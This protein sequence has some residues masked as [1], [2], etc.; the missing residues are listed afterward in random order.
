LAA[1][2]ALLAL[3]STAGAEDAAQML[4]HAD[5]LC[6]KVAAANVA[7]VVANAEADR[8]LQRARAELLRI[9]RGG[10]GTAEPGGTPGDSAPAARPRAPPLAARRGAV[11]AAAAFARRV[12]QAG[13][14]AA[15]RGVCC[16]CEASLPLAVGFSKKQRP[17][18]ARVMGKCKR[19]VAATCGWH[20]PA[21]SIVGEAGRRV[22]AAHC[23]CCRG[24]LSS[25]EFSN[26]QRGR[27]K[28]GAPARCKACVHVVSPQ[29]QAEAQHAAAAAARAAA[30]ASEAEVTSDA[31]EAA[32]AR[33]H[34]RRA[35]RDAGR[36]AAAAVAVA[37]ATNEGEGPVF[38]GGDGGLGGLANSWPSEFQDDLGRSF[39]SAEHFLMHRKAATVGDE[40]RC[41]LILA[42]PARAV[43]LGRLVE[44]LEEARWTEHREGW[45][46]DALWRKFNA[47]PEIARRLLGTGGRLLL[48]SGG[49]DGALPDAELER[50]CTE[51][52]HHGRAL[53]RARSRLRRAHAIAQHCGALP[54]QCDPVNGG[55]DWELFADTL[56][57][58]DAATCLRDREVVCSRTGA[59]WDDVGF[60]DV[61]RRVPTEGGVG[62]SDE[63]VAELDAGGVDR[64][65]GRNG[66][67]DREEVM[68]TFRLLQAEI[69]AGHLEMFLERAMMGSA[70][71]WFHPISLVTKNKDGT[72]KL[73]AVVDY[74]MGAVRDGTYGADLQPAF[75]FID[76]MS[77]GK[78]PAL[79][80][81]G[82]RSKSKPALDSLNAFSPLSVPCT[83]D[84]VPYISD[85]IM[86]LKTDGGRLSGGAKQRVQ[87]STVDISNAYRNVPLKRDHRRLF[88]FRF[89]DVTK[90]IPQYVLDGGQ[91]RDADC[92]YYRKT[93]MPFGWVGSVDHWVR[94]SKALKALHMWDGCPGVEARVPRKQRP[95]GS[96]AP[97]HAS[98][99]YLDDAGLFGVVDDDGTNWA[100]VSQERYLELCGML[101]IPI[102]LEKLKAEGG[103][104]WVVAML[105]VLMDC[106]EEELRLSPARLEMLAKR[107]REVQGK[108][109]VT[110]KELRNLVGILSFA[111]SCAPAGRTFMRRLYDAQKRKGKFCRINRGLAVDLAWWIKFV[112]ADGGWHGASML[113]EEF[114][115][116]AERLGLFT[117]A[118]LEGFAGTFVLPDGT[119][120]VFSGR[121]DEVL[122]GIDTSQATGEW[123]ISELELLV[124]VMALEQWSA[125]LTQR[126][127]LTRCD[128]ESAVH[129]IN[130]GRAKDP[131]MS[132]LLRE[133]WFVKAR[134]S[135]EMQSEHIKT[136]H[137]R[138]A[139]DP[140]RWTRAD[141]TRDKAIEAQFYAF[142]AEHFGLERE[143]VREVEVVADT[144]ALLR[145]MRKAHAGAVH[146]LHEPDGGGDEVRPGARCA[147]R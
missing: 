73:K 14:A 142:A 29:G 5:A 96:W 27:L 108:A 119:C 4:E 115:T 126:R 88:C 78:V 87:G 36:A 74:V 6:A 33:F 124:V 120:E 54:F 80:P 93:V 131:A 104:D 19:C 92:V 26:S 127:V 34:W 95:D 146:R 2:W 140:S 139:D 94:L 123:H 76:N 48:D 35:A 47:H 111:A 55:I 98:A 101:G 1:L 50:R 63:A 22:W 15:E 31:L 121:W 16:G 21:P 23:A 51:G 28:R 53:M 105:G 56:E 85:L 136:H 83:L 128:N 77:A 10:G 81:E 116:T 137:N 82:R 25:D 60:I 66:S 134:G 57:C 3:A 143:D 38:L 46:G 129:A 84:D 8:E 68:A 37:E 12:E 44:P 7:A 114:A 100:D 62:A 103:V 59:R 122:P 89:L 106:E 117:D 138:M 141:G 45:V 110:K 70:L 24:E 69:E 64:V 97:Q 9:S 40:A 113:V 72:P 17:R 39:A 42:E 30:E 67:M 49:G 11:A 125:H 102:S 145:R 107:C 86:A 99:I 18:V 109:Y 112:L 147:V 71:C 135:F 52:N 130:S 91:P 75:R 90:P 20:D 43:E 79:T 61:L 41:A 118:S 65:A 132:L 133:L 58:Y 13:G 32:L 144:V